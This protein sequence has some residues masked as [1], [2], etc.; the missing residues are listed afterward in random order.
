MNI[1]AMTLSERL[2]ADRRPQADDHI[3]QQR[4]DRPRWREG[5]EPADVAEVESDGQRVGKNGLC[6]SCR[7]TSGSGGKQQGRMQY[8]WHQVSSW[9][10]GHA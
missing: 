9:K 5:V 7:W 2:F 8:F 10:Q 1:L 4:R 6:S 3:R